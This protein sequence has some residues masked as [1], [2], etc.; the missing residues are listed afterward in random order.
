M[1]TATHISE[2]QYLRTF[3]WEPDAEY[4]DG[5]VRTRSMPTYDHADWQQAIQRWFVEHAKEWN[6]RSVSE[7][8]MRVKPGRYRIPDVSVLDRANPKEQVATIPPLAVFEVLSP[9]DRMQ[10]MYEKLEDYVA[11]GIPQIWIVDP[12][13]SVFKQYADNCLR[14]ASRFDLSARGIQFDLGEI[15]ALLQD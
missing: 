1:S 7:L 14:P 6:V 8:R 12:K 10:E 15:A 5:E 2:E 11:M 3:S 4:V 9:E 13:T